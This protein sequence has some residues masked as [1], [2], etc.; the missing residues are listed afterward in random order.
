M[1]WKQWFWISASF[2]LLISL[3][4]HICL[5]VSEHFR[6][7]LCCYYIYLLFYLYYHVS[8]LELY[9]KYP[10]FPF[11]EIRSIT[12][13]KLSEKRVP[14]I[15]HLFLSYIAIFLRAQ[16]ENKRIPLSKYEEKGE[17]SKLFQRIYGWSPLY[18]EFSKGNGVSFNLFPFTQ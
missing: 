4:V 12:C 15:F 7:T 8:R 13:P 14:Y 18:Q 16:A 5:I 3:L 6:F 10:I 17:M 9:L 2:G 11:L 1:I